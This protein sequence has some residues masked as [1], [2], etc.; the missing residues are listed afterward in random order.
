MRGL[1]VSGESA[2]IA[3]PDANNSIATGT[4]NPSILVL[5]GS[6]AM[7]VIIASSMTKNKAVSP[8]AH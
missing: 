1:S 7:R 3:R 5:D 2:A 4:I 8:P 6:S